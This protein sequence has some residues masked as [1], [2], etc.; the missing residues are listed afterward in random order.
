LGF[1]VF[2]H[3]GGNEK[4]NSDTYLIGNPIKRMR[5]RG[6]ADPSTGS[7]GDPCRGRIG[8]CRNAH[9][10]RTETGCHFTKRTDRDSRGSCRCA[11]CNRATDARTD[12]ADCRNR[13]HCADKKTCANTSPQHR[14]PKA[15][16][17]RNTFA[18]PSDAYR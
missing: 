7:G 18:P 4:N 17:D 13:N 16:A 15:F 5:W 11:N 10:R 14:N 1:F 8:D 3:R 2:K 9:R 6:N 12:S